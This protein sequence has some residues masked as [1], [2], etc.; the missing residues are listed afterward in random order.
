MWRAALGGLLLGA[1]VAFL[2]E[3]LRPRGSNIEASHQIR[4]PSPQ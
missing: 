3:L 2:I 4:T 1:V